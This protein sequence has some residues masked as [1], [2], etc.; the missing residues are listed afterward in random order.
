MDNDVDGNCN[1]KYAVHEDEFDLEYK[2]GSN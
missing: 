2:T 1:V